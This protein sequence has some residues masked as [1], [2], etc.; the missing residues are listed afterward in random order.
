MREIVHKK[1]DAISAHTLEYIENHTKYSPEELEKLKTTA[2]TRKTD[3]NVKPDFT[4]NSSK[5]DISFVIYGCVGAKPT[6]HKHLDLG[7]MYSCKVPRQF[8]NQYFI[9]R[10]MW[11]SYDDVTVNAGPYYPDIVVGG[12]VD[13]R[14]FQ[15]PEGPR[16]AMKWTVR[17]VYSIEDRLRNIPY[18]DPTS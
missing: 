4:L 8:H 14:I 6:I 17:N 13:F 2:S 3:S 10:A 1:F 7:G 5:K 9:I 15:Y 12:V 16:P 18:P 11:R